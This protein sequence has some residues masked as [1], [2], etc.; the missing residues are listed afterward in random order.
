AVPCRT[1]RARRARASFVEESLFGSPAGVRSAPPS[2]DP[3]WTAKAAAPGSGPRP[4]GRCRLRSHAPSFCDEA[5]FGARHRRLDV[6]RLQPLLW[7]PPP[8]PR[9]RETPL[10]ALHGHDPALPVV[11]GSQRGSE[12][13]SCADSDS[14]SQGW[15]APGR[16]RSQS[17]SRLN[18]HL[19]RLRPAANT[20]KAEKS[21]TLRP[22]TAPATPRGPL[23]RG[24]SQS[25]SGTPRAR[26]PM[27]VDGCKRR[28]PWK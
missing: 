25:V 23:I 13:E 5:L 22:L 14:C 11:A 27:A 16:G 26:S 3:P 18:T 28:P 2:F 17:L 1:V 6:A 4:G 12:G 20:P 21:K 19:D 24:Q 8:A 7:S 10:R 15:G 9:A